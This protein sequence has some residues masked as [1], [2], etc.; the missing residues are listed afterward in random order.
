MVA[1]RFGDGGEAGGRRSTPTARSS[2]GATS[3]GATA[4]APPGRGRRRRPAR[5]LASRPAASP[6]S[7]PRT[8]PLPPGGGDR[9]VVADL[10]LPA[11]GSCTTSCRRCRCGCRRCARSARYAN[12]FAIESF[13]D[14]L[15]AAAGA[16]P[17]EFRLQ[18]L[19]DPRARAVIEAAA[20][21]A[22]WQAGANGD[23]TR[24]RGIGFAR[25]KN[26]ERLLRGRSPRSR[27]TEKIARAA[28]GRGGRRRRAD[29]SRRRRQ[30][31]RGRHHPGG[32]LDAEGSGA[33][34]RDARR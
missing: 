4:R 3:S 31:G 13:M 25:Y 20:P 26:V 15:A 34:G 11:R 14:E 9:N 24:G 2:S 10:R 33:L 12:V 19:A 16:D 32:E 23:G 1:V 6:P 21:A 17:V 7:T 18:H 30:P 5:R 28:R 27:S 8:P 29:Q 22:G